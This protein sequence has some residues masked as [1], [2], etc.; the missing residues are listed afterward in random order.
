MPLFAPSYQVHLGY[1]KRPAPGPELSF[2]FAQ[3]GMTQRRFQGCQPL[4]PDIDLNAFRFRA[5]IDWVEFQVHLSRGTQIQHVQDELRRFHPKTCRI[6][7][8][9]KEPGGVFTAC[10]IRVQEPANLATIVTMYRA[11]V[12]RFGEASSSRVTGIEVSIDAYPHDASHE[13]RARLLGAMQRTLSTSRDVWTNP[14]DR[15]RFAFGKYREDTAYLAP[16]PTHRISPTLKGHEREYR[17]AREIPQRHKPIPIDATLYLGAKG[18]P[19]MLRVMEK[20][21]DEQRGWGV[22]R[23]LSEPEKRVRIEVTL[24]GTE[25]QDSG[26]SDVFSLRDFAPSSLQG[27]YFQFRVPHFR[28]LGHV[29][30]SYRDRDRLQVFLK[31]GILGLEAMD[32]ARASR[33]ENA[34]K[35]ARLKLRQAGILTRKKRRSKGAR[36][37]SA[38]DA[39]SRKVA[40]A[41]C[42]LAKREGRAWKKL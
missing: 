34:G 40:N 18:S 5:V 38:Y 37:F 42:E 22:G 8:I 6:D 16:A 36:E 39:L 20:V 3:S 4:I 12:A 14:V 23:S 2:S 33:H 25:L 29:A 31:T 30:R 28:T 24:L 15:P 19:V 13:A 1:K 27:R 35:E 21:L 32:A 7:P 26:I 10:R 9:D 17:Y 41:L 11:L